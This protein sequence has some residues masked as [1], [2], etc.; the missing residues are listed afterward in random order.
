MP[1]LFAFERFFCENIVLGYFWV[2]I[3]DPNI[4]KVLNFSHSH[5]QA[6]K[7]S[8]NI[9]ILL[10]D[11]KMKAQN[12]IILF[13]CLACSFLSHAQIELE[14]MKK[15]AGSP[16]AS[17]YHLRQDFANNVV[18][19]GSTNGPLDLDP[20]VAVNSPTAIGSDDIYVQKFNSAGNL[21]W[22]C[23][24]GSAGADY[25]YDLEIN[26]TGDIYISGLLGGAADLDPSPTTSTP[27]FS[28]NCTFLLKLSAGGAL[29]WAKQLNGIILQTIELGPSDNIYMYG[30]CGN[31]T[32]FDPGPATFTVSGIYTSSMF[33]SKLSPSGNLIWVQPFIAAPGSTLHPTLFSKD[34]NMNFYLMGQLNGTFD[35]DIGA[36]IALLTG[37]QSKSDN[38]V[39]K[40]DSAGNFVHVGLLRNLQI[41]TAVC[42]QIDG[43]IIAG[44]GDHDAD[45]DP[46]PSNYFFS[47]Q[48]PSIF[49]LDVFILKLNVS[50]GSL[51]W[52]KGVTNSSGATFWSV[53]I[54]PGNEILASGIYVDSCN[55]LPNPTRQLK[56]NAIGSHFITQ[57]TSNGLY[58]WHVQ[59]EGAGSNLGGKIYVTPNQSMYFAGGVIG[60]CDANPGAGIA[61]AGDPINKN[62]ITALLL[63]F[64]TKTLG[65]NDNF[66]KTDFEIYP[67]PN[68]G[69]FHLHAEQNCTVE[70]YDLS[71]NLRLQKNISAG[72]K[73]VIDSQLEKGIYAVRIIAN[74]KSDLFSKLVI[75]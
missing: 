66:Y 14:W 13:L 7:N 58:R 41:T 40:L 50:N 49:G 26:P 8:E 52:V 1:L 2:T 10:A 48:T 18:V 53:Q 27:N 42:D 29:I 36:S 25:V 9:L 5:N 17:N 38:Y 3:N 54:L 21:L 74:G 56:S 62:I 73:T 23:R 6:L 19:I 68:N 12:V 31:G 33:L 11:K 55:F 51:V 64:N 59:F 75:E 71:G 4:K 30:S 65:F 35:F 39:L 44:R 32:D 16:D 28:T 69:A 70:I 47:P 61:L 20:G 43:L 72:E 15:Y 63:K 34:N 67:N 57:I 45:Y 46:G 37:S 24:I 60:E 22:A